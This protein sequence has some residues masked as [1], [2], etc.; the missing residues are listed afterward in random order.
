MEYKPSLPEHNDNISHDQP[1]RE[2]LLL[3]SGITFFLLVAF[4]AL[5][6]FVDLAVNYISPDMEAL[7]FS[8]VD[9]SES[10]L[11]HESNPPAGGTPAHG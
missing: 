3:F 4:W 2:F 6:L 7:I 8:P 10:E 5:G 11:T 9:I 1:V